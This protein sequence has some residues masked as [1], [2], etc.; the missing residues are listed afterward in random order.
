[1]TT[2]DWVLVLGINVAIVLYGVFFVKGKGSSFVDRPPVD[3]GALHRDGRSL[4]RPTLRQPRPLPIRPGERY[5]TATSGW[6]G[7]GTAGPG[8]VLR[9]GAVRRLLGSNSLGFY[10]EIETEATMPPWI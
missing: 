9:K 6:A 4:L 8:E 2:F 3:S 7:R 10:R 5:T 1:M